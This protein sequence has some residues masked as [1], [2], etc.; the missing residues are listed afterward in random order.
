MRV[1]CFLVTRLRAKVELQRSPRL[2]NAPAVIVGRERGRAVV[3]D[4]LPGASG[5]SAGMTLEEA[6]S[7]RPGAAVVEADEPAYRRV[8]RQAL[9]SL[10]GVSDRVEAGE[11]GTAY[12]RLDGLSEMYGGEARLAV[13]LLNAAPEYLLPRVGLGDGKFPAYV[14]ARTA[15]ALGAVRVPADAASF[16]APHPVGLLPVARSLTAAMRRFGI[17]TL[18]DAAAWRVEPL[19][20]RFGAEGRLAWELARG[21]DRRPL[22]PLK[23]DEAVTERL[24]LPFASVSLELVA[25][26]AERLMRRAFARPDV[27][28]RFAGWA[29]LQ[30]TLAKGAPWEKAV[31]FKR[32]VGQWEEAAAIV[33][34]QLAGDPPP[35]PVEEMTLTLGALSGGSAVQ[36]GLLP[37]VRKDRSE[38][39]VEVERQLQA[40]ANGRRALY[41]VEEV[42]AWHPAPEMRA[43][44]VPIDPLAGDEMQPLAAP[45]AA[46]VREG[47]GHRPEA[48]RVGREWRS[49]ASIE[50]RWSFDLWWTP[51]PTSRAYYLVTREDGAQETIFRDLRDGCWYRHRPGGKERP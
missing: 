35:A 20:D 26:G 8:F 2:R 44:R 36:M 16:L 47:S 31:H 17:R 51:E 21:V 34:R 7:L 30:C 22:I 49:V 42:A 9:S 28:G 13:A 18:G 39:L 41:R 10:Q 14:A 24:S 40:R 4:A 32:G 46:A 19:A 45:V 38:R 50:E 23:N 3:L 11:L 12:V 33:R 37:E 29:A 43:L 1:A 5:A 48:V 25:A 27:R 6:L 15:A